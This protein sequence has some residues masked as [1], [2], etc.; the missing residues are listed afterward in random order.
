[1]TCEWSTS[2][3]RRKSR[4]HPRSTPRFPLTPTPHNR[5]NPPPGGPGGT[6]LSTPSVN[7]E[8]VERPD[9]QFNP[10]SPKDLELVGNQ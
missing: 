7:D 4:P 2:R 9:D 1:M 5:T 8:L 10:K 6:L 3:V